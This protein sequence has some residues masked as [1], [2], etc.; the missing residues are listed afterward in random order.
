MRRF[1]ALG[2]AALL[3]A[4]GTASARQTASSDTANSEVRKAVDAGNTRYIADFAKLDAAAL[5]AL[6]VLLN[7]MLPL[8]RKQS[9]PLQ[10]RAIRVRPDSPGMARDAVFKGR[11]PL[12]FL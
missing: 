12:T 7:P 1:L 2:F 5:A 9:R 11:L 8:V 3:F 10:Q 4:G 6:H